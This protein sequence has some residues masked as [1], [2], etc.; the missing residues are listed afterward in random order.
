[1]FVYA[2]ILSPHIPHRYHQDC[3]YR[4]EFISGVHL[5]GAE[6]GA[7]YATD[8]RC[9]DQD[10]VAG[11]DRILAEDPTAVIIIQS[12][13]GSRLAFDWRI[14]FADSTAR[15]L[16]EGFG[17]VNAMRLPSECAGAS[18]EGF[19]PVNTFRLLFGCLTDTEPNLLAERNFFGEFNEAAP[20]VEV[21]PE[22]FV[23]P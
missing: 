8:V 5:S 15:T 7:A 19:A 6:R 14:T 12:D 21:P 1:V 9:L 10:V 11:V 16:N 2:H 17:V 23:E 13:H 22:R 20:L 3:S 4:H 18:I